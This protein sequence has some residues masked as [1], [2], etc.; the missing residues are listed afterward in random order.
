MN[1]AVLI[2]VLRGLF[3]ISLFVFLGW[4]CYIFVEGFAP[5]H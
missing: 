4:I 2:L 1:G 3:A 5:N